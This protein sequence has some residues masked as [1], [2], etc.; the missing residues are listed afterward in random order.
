MYI[1]TIALLVIVLLVIESVF[2]HKAS[3]TLDILEK[4]KNYT[5]LSHIFHSAINQI[6]KKEDT[7]SCVNI[8]HLSSRTISKYN[9]AIP[10][11]IINAHINDRKRFIS[12]T[13]DR[14]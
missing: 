1:P 10:G 2:V 14:F 7:C 12:K 13:H 8:S 6:M 3:I 11:I 4:K 5:F 9:V